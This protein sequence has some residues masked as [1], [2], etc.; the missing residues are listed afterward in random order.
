MIAHG[1][2]CG[3][4][5]DSF[6][7]SGLVVVL[8]GLGDRGGTCA[9][10]STVDYLVRLSVIIVLTTTHS[11]SVPTRINYLQE[12]LTGVDFSVVSPGWFQL[13][14]GI[15]SFFLSHFQTGIFA[16][17]FMHFFLFLR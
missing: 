4:G 14:S 15:D 1:P 7:R 12:A 5:L 3:H 8:L 13:S 17:Y 2:P 9:V 10:R 16:H 11:S 6:S